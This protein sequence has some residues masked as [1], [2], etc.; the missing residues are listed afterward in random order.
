[1]RPTIDE[2]LAAQ[3][4]ERITDAVPFPSD[5][6]DFATRVELLLDEFDDVVE[7]RD[8]LADRVGE[9]ETAVQERE[10]T[11]QTLQENRGGSSLI[12]RGD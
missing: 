10:E 12:S 5:R 3:V 2:D 8:E 6:L 1:M 9:L 11:I 4:D 7:E